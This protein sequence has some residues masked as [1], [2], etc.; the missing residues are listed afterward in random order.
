MVL[1]AIYKIRFEYAIAVE[2]FNDLQDSI[3]VPFFLAK[4]TEYNY[5][6]ME[7]PL[8]KNVTTG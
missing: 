6:F 5:V 2:Q 1:N 7:Y 4:V 8:M 3:F